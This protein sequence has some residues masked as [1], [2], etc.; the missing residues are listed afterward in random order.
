MPNNYVRKTNRGEASTEIY[1][2]AAEEVNLR[3]KSLRDAAKSYHLNYT[4]HRYVRNVT[5]VQRAQRH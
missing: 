1:D 5:I 4:Y 2:L 3:G